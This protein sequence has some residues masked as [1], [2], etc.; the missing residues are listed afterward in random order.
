MALM[1]ILGCQKAIQLQV[2]PQEIAVYSEGTQQLTTNVDDATFSSGDDYYASVDVN[3]LVTGNKV[4]ETVINVS[5]SH[6]SASVPIKILSQYSLYPDV[7]NLIGKGLSDVTKVFGT[8][9][10]HSISSKGED[11]YVFEYPTSYVDFIGFTM[12]G[13]KVANILVAVQTKHTSMLTKHLIERYNIAGMQN[14][15]YFFLNHGKKVTIALTVYS[16]KYLAAMYLENTS[17]KSAQVIDNSVL[18][19]F[20]SI[21]P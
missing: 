7:D 20:Q 11:M 2:T 9:Y 6:G 15:Y 4:G 21:L 5:S 12:S 13:N 10:D 19:D 16:V 8:S 14:N 1:P 17:S 3:G 18:E